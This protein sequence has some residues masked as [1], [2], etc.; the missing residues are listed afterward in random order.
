MARTGNEAT[1]GEGR[2]VKKV[3]VWCG[4]TG[5]QLPIPSMSGGMFPYIYHKNQ[6]FMIGKYT[7]R[8]MDGMG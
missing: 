3:D 6:P 7:V 5:G 2:G 1:R 4:F 8:P